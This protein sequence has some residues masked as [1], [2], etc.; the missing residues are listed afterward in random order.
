MIKK[1]RYLIS[2]GVLAAC[3]CL[4]LAGLAMLPPRAGVTKAN[5]DR[6]EIGMSQSAVC[7][8][9]GKEWSLFAGR[10]EGASHNFFAHEVWL[11][12]DGA[13]ATIEFHN[14]AVIGKIW[15]DSTET[16]PDKLRRWLHLPV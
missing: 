16:I 11:H 3:A 9:F 13:S 12:D 5:F 4:A 14:E 10:P 6:I 2:A 8:I 7:E 15:T 1:R